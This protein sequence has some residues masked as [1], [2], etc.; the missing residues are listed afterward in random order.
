L[1]YY[2]PFGSEEYKIKVVRVISTG[3]N[4][5]FGLEKCAKILLKKVS[6]RGYHT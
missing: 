6:S 5:N 3:I 4:M 1:F 2:L